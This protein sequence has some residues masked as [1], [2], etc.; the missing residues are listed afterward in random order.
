MERDPFERLLDLLEKWNRRF[1]LVGLRDRDAMR[2]ELIEDSLVPVR[3]GL[4]ESPVLDAGCG[5]GFPTL[6]VAIERPD[7]RIVAVDSS[8]KKINFLRYAVR[9]LGLGN[10]EPVRGR[11]EELADLHGTFST[12]LSKAFMPPEEA[13]GFLRPFVKEGG[14]LI[15]YTS[16]DK[17]VSATGKVIP[18]AL[19]GKKRALLVVE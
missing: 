17:A 15:V 5:A 7:V 10:V 6:P 19:G 1:N 14:K 11:L 8:R 3:L 12:V 13:V 16:L 18:Y 2:L 9:E 4:V